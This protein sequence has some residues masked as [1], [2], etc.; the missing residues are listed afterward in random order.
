MNGP[1]ELHGEQVLDA[2]P[3]FT[4]EPS[5]YCAA[6]GS[7]CDDEERRWIASARMRFVPSKRY[8]AIAGRIGS[9]PASQ[10]DASADD[11]R[12]RLLG[13][14][15]NIRR[16]PGESG[17][18][19][20]E[21]IALAIPTWQRA[22]TAQALIDQLAAYGLPGAVVLEECDYP[23]PGSDYGWR[24]L[25][26]V[27]APN[28]PPL[29][30]FGCVLGEAILGEWTLGLGKYGTR[31]QLE[32]AKRIVNDWRNAF[33]YPLRLIVTFGNVTVNSLE[34]GDYAPFGVGDAVLE[35]GLGDWRVLGIAVLGEAPLAGI[36]I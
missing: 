22:T 19:Y 27:P 13:N 23:V 7:I 30:W 33:A 32:G 21:R 6:I 16:Y 15:R 8:R 14:T 3:W 17:E 20:Q 9:V 25:V 12:L 34:L 10:D 4:G 36:E 35:E 29:N 5:Q 28:H 24:F 2:L 26:V 11:E 31:L 18:Q 1:L